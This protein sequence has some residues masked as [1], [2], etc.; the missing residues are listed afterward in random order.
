MVGA[1]LLVLLSDVDGLYTG[2][3]R[4]DPA[5]QH[6]PFVEALSRPTS[7]PW[8]DRQTPPRGSGPGAWATKLDAARIAA[9]AGWRDPDHPRAAG[10]RPWPQW[11]RVSGRP[12]LRPPPRPRPPTKAWI[13]G[14]LTPQGVLT[15]DSGAAAAL[16]RGK[17]LLAAGRQGRRGAVRQ[18]RC[19]PGAG[20]DGRELG[21][22]LARYDVAD[23]RRDPRPAHQRHRGR[24]SATR[25]GR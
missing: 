15:V 9:G 7:R 5:A 1:D 6:V 14:S 19:G 22:G 16:R 12:C 17:S 11:S 18:G 21:R 25:L 13:A 4:L 2:D 24:C 23:A 3:P 10:P 8:P 20:R